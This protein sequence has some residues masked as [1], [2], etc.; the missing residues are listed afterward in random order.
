MKRSLPPK[1][2][3]LTKAI[4]TQFSKLSYDDLKAQLKEFSRM[5]KQGLGKLNLEQFREALG[6]PDSRYVTD[7]FHLLDVTEAGSIDFREY[8]AGRALISS[9]LTTDESLQM[10]FS[11]FDDNKVSFRTASASCLTSF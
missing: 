10:A 4:K 2:L 5:D 8:I 11:S 3:I 9:E 1:K 7:L 6:L